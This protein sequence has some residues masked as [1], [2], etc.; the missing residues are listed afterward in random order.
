MLEKK[1]GQFWNMH[2]IQQKKISI[3]DFRLIF[4]MRED[5]RIKITI[6]F[7]LSRKN[8]K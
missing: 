6:T 5:V 1:Q 7:F 3:P 4:L 2:Q 8:L